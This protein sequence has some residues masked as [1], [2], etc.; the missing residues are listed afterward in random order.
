MKSKS[1]K[2]EEARIRMEHA[3][4]AGFNGNPKRTS[5]RH[6][7]DLRRKLGFP[8]YEGAE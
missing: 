2:Q 6:I 7:E 3:Y 4:A 1:L 5:L 8:P